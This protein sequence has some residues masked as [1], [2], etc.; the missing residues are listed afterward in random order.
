MLA[1]KCTKNSL[2]INHS[3]SAN[4]G[5]HFSEKSANPIYRVVRCIKKHFCNSKNNSPFFIVGEDCPHYLLNH[6]RSYYDQVYVSSNLLNH[7]KL[8]RYS[9]W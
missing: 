6:K 2:K 7:S 8:V 1:K 4:L 3:I 5:E 9:K